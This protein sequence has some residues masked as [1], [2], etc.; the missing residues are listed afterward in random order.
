MYSKHL[1]CKT[2]NMKLIFIDRHICTHVH[3]LTCK[4]CQSGMSV[5]HYEIG[6]IAI[7]RLTAKSSFTFYK[8]GP[9]IPKA[10][11]VFLKSLVLMC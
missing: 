11:R 6:D 1:K 7:L 8:Q 4:T 5:S 3:T 10:L 2:R 9:I